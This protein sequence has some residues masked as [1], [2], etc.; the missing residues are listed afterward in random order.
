MRK[1]TIPALA[2]AALLL[3]ACTPSRS[4]GSTAPLVLDT[5]ETSAVS[6]A[7]TPVTAQPTE[8]PQEVAHWVVEPTIEA[9]NIDVL[10]MGRGS[11][12]LQDYN[13]FA[14]HKD[15]GLCVITTG[16]KYGLIDYNG[17]MVVPMDYDSIQLGMNGMY[18]LSHNGGE[19]EG[20]ASWT[21][22]GSNNLVSLSGVS[23]VDTVGSA[24]NRELYWV[25][26]RD[27]LYISGGADTWL[28]ASYT[29]TVPCAGWVVTT[30]EDDCATAWDGY[31]LTDGTRPVSDTRY[32]A[33][34]AYSCGLI[35]MKLDGMWGYLDAQG[36]TVLPFEYEG[37]WAESTQDVL[38]NNASEPLPYAA[39]YGGVV[40]NKGDQYAL[41][42]TTGRNVIEF[43]SYEAL[44]PLHGDKLWAKQ[45]GKWGVLQLTQ[46]LGTSLSEYATPGAGVSVTP[47]VLE[48]R[49]MVCDADGGLVLR[50]GPGADYDR[51]GSIPKGTT[52]QVVGSSSTV[53]GW[54]YVDYGGWVSAEYLLEH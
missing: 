48:S 14:M 23:M 4:G 52:V 1:Y 43:G 51:L 54:L 21:L 40:V 7:E 3:A 6:E 46:P 44:R 20:G 8:A 13:A 31:V 5:P 27:S 19:Y 45:D 49:T 38:V 10:R 28:E 18:I 30:V 34:G 15:D 47:D 2:T 53:D 22:D 42:D 26:E 11:A 9:D 12:N 33:A 25:P 36:A 50:A 41:F 29:S 32:E 17:N 24:P 37:G 39:S 16:G 35:P